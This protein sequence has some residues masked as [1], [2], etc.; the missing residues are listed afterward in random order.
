[1][2]NIKKSNSTIIWDIIAGAIGYRAVFVSY[3]LGLF[4]FLNQQPSKIREICHHLNIATRPAEALLSSCLSLQLVEENDQTYNLSEVAREYLL[5]ESKSS[6]G[7][8]FDMINQNPFST[9]VDS[10][11]NAVLTNK[12]QTYGG[13]DI[14]QSHQE[15]VEQAKAFTRGMHS[16]SVEPAS[17]WP[18]HINLSNHLHLLDIGGGSGAHAIGAL[19]HWSNLKATVFDLEPVCAVAQEYI[20]HNQLEKRMSSHSGDL[21]KSDFPLADIHFYSQIFHDWP[22]DKCQFLA[23]KSFNSLTSGGKIIIHEILYDDDKSGPFMAA[24]SSIAMLVWTEGKQYSGAEITKMLVEAGFIKPKVTPTTGYW[25][26]IS[27]E[28]P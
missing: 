16:I 18:E 13:G 9:S 21:W 19:S 6:F 5:Q 7:A 15:Q 22:I 2:E 10:L 1:M 17:I 4:E 24:A 14:F 12:P 20:S 26:I 3:E 11:K 23:Q 27:A 28:K 25:S 8:L